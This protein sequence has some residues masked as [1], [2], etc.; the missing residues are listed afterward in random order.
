[1][2]DETAE[3][4]AIRLKG[5]TRSSALLGMKSQL[6]KSRRNAQDMVQQHIGGGAA[7]KNAF[8]A[9]SGLVGQVQAKLDK[10]EISASDA[11]LVIEHLTTVQSILR[12]EAKRSEDSIKLSKGVVLGIEQ[13]VAMAEKQATQELEKAETRIERAAEGDDLTAKQQHQ[14]EEAER[15]AKEALAAGSAKK[16]PAKRTGKK[17]GR[18]SKA[19]IAAREAAAKAD[20]ETPAPN[21][22]GSPD[23][24]LD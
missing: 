2:S 8:Q 7:C 13:A 3:T 12:S 22:K 9:V 15:I 16:K 17:R 4:E 18:P 1:M 14:K 10:A 21:G 20:S 19:D 11:S 5:A 6:D 23:A 24:A